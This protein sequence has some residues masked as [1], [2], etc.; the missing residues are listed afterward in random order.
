MKVEGDRL[1]SFIFFIDLP[2]ATIG[3]VNYAPED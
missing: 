1:T 3:A 2:S